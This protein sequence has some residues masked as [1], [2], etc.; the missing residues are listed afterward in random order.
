MW[1]RREVRQQLKKSYERFLKKWNLPVYFQIR[2]QEI[3]GTAESILSASVT[4]S[5][6][7]N[8]DKSQIGGD[9]FTLHATCILWDCLLRVTADDAVLPQLLHR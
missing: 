9:D 2:F 6:I 1:Q 4:P 8:G 3:A 5:S 7:R